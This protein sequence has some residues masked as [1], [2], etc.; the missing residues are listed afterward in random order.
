[1][2]TAIEHN[3]PSGE[4]TAFG[5]RDEV[6]ALMSISFFTCLTA[7]GQEKPS[8][9]IEDWA[10]STRYCG[11]VQPGTWPRESSPV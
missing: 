4:F 8:A 3:R 7:S 11:F 5:R 6:P 9:Q 1:M 10:S 2:G